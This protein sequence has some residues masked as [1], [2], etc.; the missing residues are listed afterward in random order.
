LRLK[1]MR[2]LLNRRSFIKHAGAAGIAG[3]FGFPAFV[4]ASSLG[5]AAAAAANNRITL[6]FIGL[7]AKGYDGVWG[8]L[9]PS[10]IENKD[11]QV[12][13]VCDVDSRYLGRAK[14]FVDQK[15]GNT[16][17]Q[18]YTDY[19][20]MLIRDDIDAVVIATP[21]HWH[22]FQAIDACKYGKDVYCEKPLSL[23]IP[24]ARA[25]VNA[26]RKYNRVFQTGSQSRSNSRLRF[27][28]EA[29]KSGRLGKIKSISAACG[30]PPVYYN[31]PAEPTPDHIDWD[32]W[33]GPSVYRPFSGALHPCGFRSIV[34]YG[35]G[36]IA[37]WGAHH[38]DLVQWALG[39][40]YTGPAE[41][42][43]PD[44]D[45]R[46]LRFRY[47]DGT[48]VEHVNADAGMPDFFGVVFEGTEG[49]ISMQGISGESLYEPEELGVECAAEV[50]K[51]SDMFSN[52]GHY[53]N[54]LE[55]VRNRTK[56]VADVEIGARSVSMS[57][58]ASICYW[59]NRPI[60]WNPDKEEI[61][62]DPEA[63]RMLS[64]T[65]REPFKL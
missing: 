59:V 53:D 39:T 57:H 52:S 1:I 13:A 54:F 12:L 21:D 50:I 47:K 3:A 36:G 45:H 31:H 58:L 28:C 24:E 23:T 4:K 49:K 38:F 30:G 22:A 26:A 9:L 63:S 19:G 20:D 43:P 41:I 48:E 25:M 17:C 34:G 51:W 40:D 8:A 56:P 55:S 15:Y 65:Y 2:N 62:G 6:G 46:W 18:T 27:N 29:I 37:D 5:S 10:F 60:R 33:I 32:R 16:D 64:R 44:E 61:V 11:C 42:L 7:G 14:K 35:G